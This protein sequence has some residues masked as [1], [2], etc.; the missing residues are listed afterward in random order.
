MNNKIEV[1]L[2]GGPKDGQTWEINEVKP[3]IEIAFRMQ[4]RDGQMKVKGVVKYKLKSDASPPEY[5]F[6]DSN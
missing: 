6:V 4:E 2:V 5:E 1:L 3:E